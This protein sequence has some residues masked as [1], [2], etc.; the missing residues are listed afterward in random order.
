MTQSTKKRQR[1]GGPPAPPE[2][3]RK[4]TTKEELA[5]KAD[6]VTAG[7]HSWK[8]GPQHAD[9][10]F[11]RSPNRLHPAAE[12]DATTGT[13][14]N[15]MISRQVRTP[16][17]LPNG[18][19]GDHTISWAVTLDYA[20]ALVVGQPL[21]TAAAN[22]RSAAA[23]AVNYFAAP[24]GGVLLSEAPETGNY[25]ANLINST[26]ADLTTELDKIQ[27]GAGGADTLAQAT[28][29]F[30]ELLNYLPFST[31]PAG[32]E[33][34]SS[35]KGEGGRRTRLVEFEA[36]A[37]EGELNNA[38]R[39]ALLD[40]LWGMFDMQA[41]LRAS[42]AMLTIDKGR[43]EEARQLLGQML[44]L[45]A[46][47]AKGELS[48]RGQQGPERGWRATLEAMLR[49]PVD[50]DQPAVRDLLTTLLGVAKALHDGRSVESL[51]ATAQAELDRID[52]RITDLDDLAPTVLSYLLVKHQRMVAAT[53]PR[54]AKEANFLDGGVAARTRLAAAIVQRLGVTDSARVDAMVKAMFPPAGKATAATDETMGEA[55]DAATDE[56]MSEATDET[57]DPT[58]GEAMSEATDPAVD[59]DTK[60]SIKKLLDVLAS[61]HPGGITLGGEGTWAAKV[62]SGT[63]VVTDS[64]DPARPL[65]INGRAPNPPGV[66]GMGSHSTSWDTETRAVNALVRD[67]LAKKLDPVQALQTRMLTELGTPD[68]DARDGKPVLAVMELDQFLPAYQLGSGQVTAIFREA[69]RL[70]K[71]KT[72]T[73]A[74]AAYLRFR[75][76]LPYATVDDGDRGGKAEGSSNDAKDH[77]DAESLIEAA[78]THRNE[79]ADP[80]QRAELAAAMESAATSLK[81]QKGTWHK[82]LHD[83]VDLS[84]DRLTARASKL[85]SS[86]A[87]SD[88]RSDI[89]HA[90]A[91]E[92]NDAA[93]LAGRD[94]PTVTPKQLESLAVRDRKARG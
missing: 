31:V 7:E 52:K 2:K 29:L 75:N 78:D 65:T 50:Q 91:A 11:I 89:L 63:L 92:H 17:P 54:A 36:G 86:D 93:T 44:A 19:M 43:L 46:R 41:A 71:A 5:K 48:K 26:F 37:F 42:D 8:L 66:T 88:G 14:S 61:R 21:A 68:S 12:L 76:Q 27:P 69:D 57:A 33:K 59:D 56:T 94:D 73:E 45:A 24:P 72:V 53:Y 79:V 85:T 16:T 22:L 3:R 77:I 28:T 6:L 10:T 9:P 58:T 70:M 64:G 38:K 82:D 83:A 30:L 39:A 51:L 90:R 60:A 67:A 13:V 49:R 55:T 15:L 74:A 47:N 23:S 34:G 81:A 25:R 40:D 4:R 35:G 1:T 87:P 32:S 20:R 18:R 84:V 62:T 80:I